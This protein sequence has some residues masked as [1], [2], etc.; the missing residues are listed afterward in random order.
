[1]PKLILLQFNRYVVKRQC[2]DDEFTLTNFAG[3]NN[4]IGFKIYYAVLIFNKFYFAQQI[5]CN[6]WLV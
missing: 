2:Y 1:M 3:F 6:I 4:K 5:N